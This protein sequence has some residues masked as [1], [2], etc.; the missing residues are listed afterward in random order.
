M[1]DRF[2]VPVLAVVENMASFR[3]GCPHCGAAHDLYPFGR[4][5]L[6]TVLQH[7]APISG[8]VASFRLPIV[9]KDTIDDSAT[10]HTR[11]TSLLENEIEALALAV[12]HGTQD[13]APVELPQLAWH[14]RPSWID[15]LFFASRGRDRRHQNDKE[16]KITPPRFLS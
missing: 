15:K 11:P 6:D 7:I 13:A 10:A 1:L 5:H 12:E 2:S 9:S 14:E 8:E 16:F 4:G 3:A